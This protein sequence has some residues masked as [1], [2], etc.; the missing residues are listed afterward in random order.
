MSV[1]ILATTPELRTGVPQQL[2]E[3]GFFEYQT[4]VPRTY[5]VTPTG[6]FLMIQPLADSGARPEIVM[7]LNWFEELKRLVPPGKR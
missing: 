5:D 7:V 2:F 1:K 4:S 3:G 6:E